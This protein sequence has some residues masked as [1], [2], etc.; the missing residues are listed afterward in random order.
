MTAARRPDRVDPP[1]PH[2]AS[3]AEH[4]DGA[5]DASFD[6]AATDERSHAAKSTERELSAAERSR[7]TAAR[8]SAAILRDE[9][10]GI[11]DLT[12]TIRDRAADARDARADAADAAAAAGP[13]ST[14]EE[15]S[16]R[17]A[18]ARDRRHA[19]RDRAAA[20]S[21][22]DAAMVDRQRAAVDR[23]DAGLD[24]L[25][26]VF[27]RGTGELALNHE[28]Q[29]ARRSGRALVLALIDVDG[30]K[31]VNDAYGHAAGDALL[32][33][34]PAAIVAT[35]RSYDVTVRWGGDEFVCA[36]S[37]A[38]MDV[39]RQ[40]ISE[41]G[42]LLRDLNPRGSIS[43]GLAQL[44]DGDSLESL[45]GRADAALYRSKGSRLGERS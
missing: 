8:M 21:D 37:D 9:A 41:I 16:L 15:A 13:G 20:A 44:A 18:A 2:A 31:A 6:R 7:M 10:A 38:T 29:R 1:P 22:R 27:R 40:R 17:E 4:A 36:L 42:R 26:G 19:A 25:T 24:E 45:I 33:D 12:A 43:A 11:R 34:V 30:L 3:H 5:L 35:L 39:A 32:R 23:R 14:G 28:I